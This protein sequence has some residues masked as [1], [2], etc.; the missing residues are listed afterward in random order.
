M[1]E[2]KWPDWAT[3]VEDPTGLYL[4]PQGKE[5]PWCSGAHYGDLVCPYSPAYKSNP[6]PK[7]MSKQPNIPGDALTEEQRRLAYE[8]FENERDLIWTE[9]FVR[10]STKLAVYAAVEAVIATL[11]ARAEKAEAALER[12]KDSIPA[13]RL[14]SRLM[15]KEGR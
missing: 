2:H 5:C 7:P 8:A 6:W 9:S 1:S 14:A 3:G 13:E 4:C 12:T 15:G 11:K 10:G